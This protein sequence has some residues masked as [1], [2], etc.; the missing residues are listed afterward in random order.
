MSAN[1]STSDTHAANN[2][3]VSRTSSANQKPHSVKAPDVM[4]D[5]SFHAF[6]HTVDALALQQSSIGLRIECKMKCGR[7]YGKQFH[8]IFEDCLIFYIYFRSG[9]SNITPASADE[10]ARVI[11]ATAQQLVTFDRLV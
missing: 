8:S 10:I 6:T 4:S 1:S 7:K 5:D 11:A 9:S 2:I 3:A